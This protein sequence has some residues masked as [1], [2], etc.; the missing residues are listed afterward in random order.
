MPIA[1]R[2]ASRSLTL[3]KR[4]K[5]RATIACKAPAGRPALVICRGSVGLLAVRGWCSVA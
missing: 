4:M 3:I 2:M 5:I 1:L